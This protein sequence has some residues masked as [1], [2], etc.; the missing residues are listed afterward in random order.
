MSPVRCALF[1]A[2]RP[3]GFMPPSTPGLLPCSM[4]G[5]PATA[6]SCSPPPPLSLR[7]SR[8]CSPREWARS[9]R[10]GR[11]EP[12]P[13]PCAP[14]SPISASPMSRS[15]PP[16]PLAGAARMFG[17]LYVLEGSRLGAKLLVPD[18]LAGGSTRVRAATRYLRHGEGH[19]LWQSFLAH[20]ESSQAT[21]RVPRR[22][23]RRRESGVR[24]VRRRASRSRAP[25]SAGRSRDR[26]CRL[27]TAR[28]ST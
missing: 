7:W 9:C 5:K 20:L 3:R 25:R 19:R 4:P 24:L 15:R 14:T 23:H 8:L 18:L 10:T 21:R 26:R 1:C 6:R 17:A 22:G 27:T 2:L 12:A 16:P 28:P 11:G 13:R